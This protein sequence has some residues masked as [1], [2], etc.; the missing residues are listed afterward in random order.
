VTTWQWSISGTGVPKSPGSMT[1]GVEDV[2]TVTFEL[3]GEV[4]EW[5]AARGPF[6]DLLD[7]DYPVTI[8]IGP[9]ED[10]S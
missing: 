10:P 4:V 2:G 5:L 1:H 3:M 9:A 7:T 6:W 8:T